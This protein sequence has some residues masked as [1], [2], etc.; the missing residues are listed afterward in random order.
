M[1]RVLIIGPKYYNFLPAVEAAFGE[2]GWETAVLGYS[3]PVHPYNWINKCRYKLSWNK[4]ALEQESLGR[5]QQVVLERFRIFK[6][7]LV[8]VLNGDFLW[9]DTLD[10]LRAVSKVALWM[11]DSLSRLPG[12]RGHEAHVDALFCFDKEDVLAFAQ[13]GV[14]A[15]FLPQ[16]CDP[17]RY[18]PIP[19][20]RK[21]IDVLFVGNMLYS[22]RR[23]RLTN[24]LIDHFPDRKILVYGW[25]QPWFKGLGKWLKRPHKRIFRN[26]NV[27]SEKANILYN[28][29]RIVLNIHQEHQKDGA[30]PRVFE[31]CGAGAYQLCDWNPYIASLFPA[32]TLGLYHDEAEL[33]GMVRDSLRADTAE[34]ASRAH[35]IVMHQ[36]TFK[37]RMEQVLETLSTETNV[38]SWEP[39]RN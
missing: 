31:I 35:R 16:A 2:L 37:N 14:K 23:K 28:R 13:R 10:S 7:A 4:A 26:V 33:I 24:A 30:N 17:A 32:G 15:Y 25:Y 9:T 5:F 29:A 39:S 11:F 3:A 6:P 34:A 27:S 36:H 12:A 8:F 18:Y 1:S 22:T 38:E 21:D 20:I 19:G